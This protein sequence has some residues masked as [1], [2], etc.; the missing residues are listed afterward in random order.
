MKKKRLTL[1]IAGL[2][3]V[4]AAPAAAQLKFTG[5]AAVTGIVSSETSRN[6]WRFEEYRDM[7][8]GVAGSLD[9]L[10]EK[11]AYYLGV[12]GDN[13]GRD[14]YTVQLFGGR[15]GDFKYSIYNNKIVHNLTFG[16]IT[17]WTGVGSNTLNFP[18]ANAAAAAANIAA[19]TPFNYGVDHENTGG[20]FEIS[21][22][23]PFYFRTTANHKESKGIRPLGAA[24]T[25][26]GGPSYELALPVDF[27]TTDFGAEAGYSTRTRHFAIQASYS[28]FADHND[29]LTWRNPI[30]TAG[31]TLFERN[32][33]SSDNELWKIGANAMWKQLPGASTFAMRGTYAQLTNSIPIAPTFTSVVGT[34]GNARLSNPS[35]P[36]FEGDIVYTTFSASL[37]SQPMTPLDTRIYYNFNEKDNNSTRVVF[38]PSGPGSGGACDINPLTGT[39]TG[40]TTC[41]NEIFHYKKHNAGVE[42]QYRVNRTNR[43]GAGL[44]YTYTERERIDFDKS[45]AWKTTL[46]WK[47]TSLENLSTRFKYQYLRRNSDFLQANDPNFYTRH[48]YRFDVAPLDQNL[49]KAVFDYSPAPLVDLGAELIYKRNDFR[50]TAYLGRKRDDRREL[51]LSAGFGD[52]KVFRVTTFFDVE[53]TSYDS[54]HAVGTPTT[55]TF[56][57]PG[58]ATPANYLWDGNVKEKN[59]VVGIAA[60]WPFREWVKFAGSLIW[61]QADGTADFA[62]QNNV[63]VPQNIGAYDS[64]RK[65]ALNLKG[66][67]QVQKNVDLTVGAAYERFKYS[68]ASFDDYRYAPLTGTNQNFLSGAYASPSYNA[69]IVY[70]TLRYVMK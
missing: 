12:R 21:L 44:D 47:N 33:I 38:T 11:D 27:T 23:S 3:T 28:K 34:T 35:S 24:G 54:T 53:Y 19:W 10:G 57:P 63:V 18:F 1:I 13:L 56:P 26:P 37:S 61:Q 46:E 42:A 29:F 36:T 60:E 9:I 4:A 68:D 16:A 6:R 14:D 69:R 65:L 66:T 70:L 40:S 51:Y 25:S 17:P 8:S 30:I 15:Y 55:A 20:L 50:D 43:I 32:T 67:T 5:S 22:N 39:T 62:T 58:T 49:V 41:T 2:F 48:L 59:Y 52:P 7:G 64:F 31:T 45:D